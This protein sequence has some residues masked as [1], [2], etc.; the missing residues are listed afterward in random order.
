[1][2][3]ER[4]RSRLDL[5]PNVRGKEDS[6]CEAMNRI[7]PIGLVR[8]SSELFLHNWMHGNYAESISGFLIGISTY[9]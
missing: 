5:N 7:L 1:V 6:G 4:P 8:L 3:R 2:S 9:S